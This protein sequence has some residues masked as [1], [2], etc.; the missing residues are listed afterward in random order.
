[1]SADADSASDARDEGCDC[2]EPGTVEG[3]ERVADQL[4]EASEA[5][6]RVDLNLLIDVEVR[7]VLDVKDDLHEICLDHRQSQHAGERRR[8]QRET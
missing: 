5:L 2:V 4:A 3:D 6:R 7:T 1:M 8:Q